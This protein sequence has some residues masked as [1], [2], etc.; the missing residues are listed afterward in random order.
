MHK[1]AVVVRR[2]AR[3]AVFLGSERDSQP[4][5]G[6]HNDPTRPI[7]PATFRKSRFKEDG[8]ERPFSRTL[9]QEQTHSF[10]QARSSLGDRIA[11]ARNIEFRSI[12]HVRS[13]FLPNLDGEV[14]LWN[15][16]SPFGQQSRHIASII[17][18]PN[19]LSMGDRLLNGV[20]VVGARSAAADAP[21][22]DP[23]TREGRVHFKFR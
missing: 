5:F 7:A 15:F 22:A 4:D 13:P 9:F 20:A 2:D 17:V 11:A 14:N 18:P 12:A 3:H 6:A 19:A 23:R 8:V 10:T 21:T 16:S 1:F